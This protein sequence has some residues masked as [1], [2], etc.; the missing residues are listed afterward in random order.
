MA[1]LPVWS[2][3]GTEFAQPIRGLLAT[4]PESYAE[5]SSTPLQPFRPKMVASGAERTDMDHGPPTVMSRSNP[6][7]LNKLRSMVD[8]PNTDEFIRWSPAGDTF[9]VPNHVRFGDEVLPRFFKHNNFSSFVRQLN[10]YGFHKVPHLQQGALKHDQPS[11]NELWEFSNPCFHRD[12]PELLSRVQRKRSGKEREHST[13]LS[14]DD[15]RQIGISN[16]ALTRGEIMPRISEIESTGTSITTHQL[17]N[18]M[19]AI[20]GIKNNQRTLL[21]EISQLQ[22]SSHALWQQ[23]IDTRQQTRKQQ[24]TIN[25]ILRFMASV[26]GSSNVGDI[27]QS[28][29]MDGSSNASGPQNE[30]SYRRVDTPPRNQNASRPPKR[31]R[32]LISDSSYSVD[33]GEKSPYS[34]LNGMENMNDSSQYHDTH[35]ADNKETPPNSWTRI[36][37]NLSPETLKDTSLHSSQNTPN[38]DGWQQQ[39]VSFQSSEALMNAIGLQEDSLNQSGNASSNQWLENLLTSAAGENSSRLDPQMLAALQ[40]ALTNQNDPTKS[41]SASDS[42]NNPTSN[43]PWTQSDSNSSS[44]QWLPPSLQQALVHTP[45]GGSVPLAETEQPAYSMPEAQFARNVQQ[46]NQHVQSNVEQTSK[47]Q[48]SIN[49]LVQSLRIDPSSSTTA[50]SQ[51]S[52]PGGNPISNLASPSTYVSSP[53][54]NGNAASPDGNAPTDFDLDSFLNQF[55]EPMSNITPSQTVGVGSQRNLAEN[56]IS[57]SPPSDKHSE[58]SSAKQ[59]SQN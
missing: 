33:S 27:L 38:S 37:E 20:Q 52:N 47:L 29:S 30:S 18:L 51:S 45:R 46:M 1:Q 59:E 14:A 35:Q 26:F 53:G 25:R 50:A 19:T 21:D 5:S 34:N 10:M 44:S 54:P 48:N 24:D 9:L 49:S 40:N 6:A 2:T 17:N 55:V 8:D 23:S 22:H 43:I 36:T 11:Q 12:Q 3:A 28:A 15:L 32:L 4:Q 31:Q 39:P 13:Q 58:F 42:I 41:A 16:N 57:S 7:F 56:T